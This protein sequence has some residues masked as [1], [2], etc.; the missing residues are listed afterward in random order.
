M[1]EISGLL[2]GSLVMS[3][4]V[5]Y[6]LIVSVAVVIILLLLRRVILF[7]LTR[8][9]K[10]ATTLYRWRKTATYISFFIGIIIIGR[11]W[12][13]GFSSL[14][15]FLGLASAGITIALRDPIVDIAGW[16]F[17][18]WRRPLET[19]DR[20]QVGEHK[21]DVID[22]RVFQF[23]ILEVGN[24]VDAD[25][26]TG[27][28]IN[29]PNG[30]VFTETLVN[31][32]TGFEYIWN[33]MPV[34]LTFESEWEKAKKLLDKIAQKRASDIGEEINKKIREAQ[35]KYMI[36]YST[37]TPSVYTSVKDSG[38]LLTVRY[39]TSAR[40]RR[41]TE[42]IIW[43]DILKEFAKHDDI[44]FAYPTQRRYDNIREGKPGARAE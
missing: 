28:I 2:G 14:S 5:Q 13:V 16:A 15:T 44:D 29:I 10:D 33:E 6:K 41:E 8:K 34:L 39:M 26:S 40:A 35:K 20:I 42:Q 23:S 4:V 36:Q 38:V 18:L 27:R 21:G 25:Q 31:Y 24:W 17:I 30:K 12:V 22:I 37:V 7:L 43:E 32:T 19:G 11:T 1:G 3:D 9:I